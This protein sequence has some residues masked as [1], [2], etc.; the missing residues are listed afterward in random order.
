MKRL[1]SLFLIP[2]IV[3]IGLS[4]CSRTDPQEESKPDTEAAETS[5][6]TEN[7]E[8]LI[9]DDRTA[10]EDVPADPEAAGTEAPVTLEEIPAD[11]VTAETAEPAPDA[12]ISE[13]PPAP[14]TGDDDHRGFFDFIDKDP[15]FVYSE[16][17]KNYGYERDYGLG[18]S[19]W[20]SVWD[21]QISAS[22][23]SILAPE[24]QYS[25]EP[26]NIYS[27]DRTNSWVEGV[28]GDGIGEYIE[29]TRRYTVADQDYGV[30]FRELCVVNGYAE[31][32]EKWKANSRVADL[33]L[34]FNGEYVDTLHLEDTIAPQYF[35]LGKYELHADSDADSVFR[36]E[37][38]S[39]YP[40]EKY[41]D[42]AITGIE[43]E[44]WTPN[45]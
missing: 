20:C 34:Y 24:G 31:N 43:L 21:Y 36:F 7:S 30:D 18:C 14:Q 26:S 10:V 42:T 9:A 45:H 33:I 8:T 22:A 32:A 11:S 38:A 27:S 1:I 39:V 15:Y 25:Y 16:A 3:L 13:E 29:I 37:I 19:V 4:A 40:G 23:S 2:A 35:D 41:E 6:L 44:F 17:G 5:V 28:E 12:E